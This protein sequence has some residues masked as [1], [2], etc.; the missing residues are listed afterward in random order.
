MLCREK[1]V[2]SCG[3]PAKEVRILTRNTSKTSLRGRDS[4]NGRFIP[5]TVAR[6][7]PKTTEVERIPKPGY[8]IADRSK[9][10]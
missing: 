10:K 5:V 4:G 6:Q 7:H 8:G 9:R 3:V 2:T 1:V